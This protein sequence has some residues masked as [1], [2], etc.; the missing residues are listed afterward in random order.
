M[1]GIWVFRFSLGVLP[2]FALLGGL[3]FLDSYRLVS[4]R[5][6]LLAAGWGCGVA[7]FCFGI[8]SAAFTALG[9]TGEWYA[10]FGAPILEEAAKA[11]WIVW[12]VRTARVGFMVDAAICGLSVGAGFALA[13][14]VVDL[15]LFADSTLAVWVLRGF[16]TAIMHGGT[17]AILGVIAARAAGERSLGG[18]SAFVPG[19]LLAISI[20]VA[21]N[22]ALLR[23]LEASIVVL[24]GLPVLFVAVFLSSEKSLRRWMGDKLDQDVEMLRTISTGGFLESNAGRYLDALCKSLPP[25]I[26]GD[27]L[28]LLTISLEL[29]AGAKGDMIR[30]E[31][32]FPVER[33]PATAGARAHQ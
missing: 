27:M 14:N 18:A 7:F 21:W 24:L 26:V 16:G 13:E 5:R 23:P 1:N 30:R 8:N 15:R 6:V 32:G 10:R 4:L 11:V 20:H 33:D 17:T 22:M 31:A 29:S 19:L 28:C 2:V 3:A 25:R 9:A 12:L